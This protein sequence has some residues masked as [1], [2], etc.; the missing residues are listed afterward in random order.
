MK[1]I[2]GASMKYIP[3]SHED[4]NN[5]GVLKKILFHRE[6]FLDGRLQMINWAKL[7]VGKEFNNHLHENMEEV[8]IILNGEVEIIVDGE[9]D[10]LSGGDAVF[11]PQKKAHQMKNLGKKD[12]HYIA[13]GVAKGVRGK[14]VNL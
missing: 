3:A 9:K 7:P 6:D 10:V 8:F 4:I 13:L 14:T 12:I 5:P 2:R 11:I 1:I